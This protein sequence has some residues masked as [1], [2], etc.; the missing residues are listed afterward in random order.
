MYSLSLG[1]VTPVNITD[2]YSLYV[3]LFVIL[4]IVLVT[5]FTLLFLSVICNYVT[6][7]PLYVL[8]L[9]DY[10]WVILVIHMLIVTC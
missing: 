4:A 8:T 6:W 10:Q 7:L 2:C 1:L 3:I 5:H 9:S